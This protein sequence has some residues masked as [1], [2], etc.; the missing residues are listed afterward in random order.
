MRL[1][2][3][4]GGGNLGVEI[5]LNALSQDIKA[6]VI[7]FEP[8]IYPALY[9]RFEENGATIMAF[10][11]GKY[12]IAGAES[13]RDLEATH[14]ELIYTI[15]EMMEVDLSAARETLELRN[16]VFVGELDGPVDL[17]PLVTALG[18]EY[19]EYEPEQFPALDYRP[20]DEAGLFKIFST[21]KVTLT[22]T[23]NPDSVDERVKRLREQVSKYTRQPV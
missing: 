15:E 18:P 1:V 21:G 22:G 12:N 3:I 5:E 6:P 11:S 20:P 17:G 8:E 14:E 23:T 19:T 2:S 7:E 10:T 16:M 9:L 4:A 13:I